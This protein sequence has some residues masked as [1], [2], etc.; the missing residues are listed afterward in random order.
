MK[1]LRISEEILVSLR[2]NLSMFGILIDIPAYVF[3]DNQSVTNNVTLPHV[4][5][6]NGHRIISYHRVLEAQASD[7]IRV[8]WI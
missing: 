6:N 3:C 7:F 2:Y 5:L 8:S 4:V 1:T